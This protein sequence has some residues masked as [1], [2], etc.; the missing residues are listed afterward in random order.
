M[1]YKR[2]PDWLKSSSII[3]LYFKIWLSLFMM[4]MV[5]GAISAATVGVSSLVGMQTIG[6]LVASLLF[7]VLYY[8][9]A[10]YGNYFWSRLIGGLP[11]GR[12]TCAASNNNG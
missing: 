3:P 6:M 1:V 7:L 4:T 12:V 2:V 9:A 11:K 5:I 8:Y 10:L